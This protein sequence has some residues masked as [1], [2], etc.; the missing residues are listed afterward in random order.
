MVNDI[1]NNGSAEAFIV[2]IFIISFA[3]FP[4][5]VGMLSYVKPSPK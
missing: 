1:F 5:H 2:N 4:V 3:L